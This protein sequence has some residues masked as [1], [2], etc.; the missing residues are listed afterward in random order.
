[1]GANA[2]ERLLLKRDDLEKKSKAEVIDFGLALQEEVRSLDQRI[3]ELERKLGMHSGN[4]SKPPSTDAPEVKATRPKKKPT[5]RK[6]GGQPG[7]KGHYRELIPADQVDDL[8]K[9]YPKKCACCGKH[10]PE[11]DD[12]HPERHQ[13]VELP[14]IKPVTHEVQCHAVACPDCQYITRAA[15]PAGVPE[16]CLGPRMIGLIAVLSGMYRLSKRKV[17]QCLQDIFR[18]KVSLGCIPSSEAT[19]SQAMAEPVREAVEHVQ[20]AAILNADETGWKEGLQKAWL[21][22]AVT[23]HVTIFMIDLSRGQDAAAKLLGK[24]RGVLGS[25]RWNG[26]NIH[27]GLRQLC[28]AHLLRTFVGWSEMNGDAGQLGGLLVKKTRLMFKW[29]YRVRDGTM[30]PEVFQK[31]MKR[32]RRKVERLITDGTNCSNQ[33]VA[34]SCKRLVRQFAHLWTFVTV[35]GVEPTNNAAERAIR[36]GV[37]WRKGSFGTQSEEGSR[38][39]ERL[40]TVVETCRQQDRNVLEYITAACQ[41]RLLQQPAPS[42][43]PV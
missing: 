17:Q 24:F 31:K 35:A 27:K 22:V 36:H 39:I 3:E 37:L 33:K 43:L 28:W 40:F 2:K 7:H 38:F 1:M 32:H 6:R 14:E 5:G 12:L 20:A 41:A 26:Y 23:L 16:G 11:Q 25:D 21:W 19:A 18:V 34:R 10:L 8:K 15:V 29:W 30:S 4:S 13:W 42:L 9:V